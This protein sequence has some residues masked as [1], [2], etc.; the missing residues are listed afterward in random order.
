[1]DAGAIVE[2]LERDY[3]R[4]PGGPSSQALNRIVALVD[5]GNKIDTLAET[6]VLLLR[7]EDVPK[8]EAFVVALDGALKRSGHCH[9]FESVFRTTEFEL[10]EAGQE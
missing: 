4:R 1:M 7:F 3:A 5:E 9:A 2:I 8:R 10:L 6:I